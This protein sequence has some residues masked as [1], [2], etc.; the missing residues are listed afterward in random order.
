MTPVTGGAVKQLLIDCGFIGT[1]FCKCCSRLSNAY[2]KVNTRFAHA[3][4][5]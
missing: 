2:C 5:G 4:G 3:T 1:P